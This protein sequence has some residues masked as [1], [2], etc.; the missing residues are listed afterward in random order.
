MLLPFPSHIWVSGTGV[1][2]LGWFSA[3]VPARVSCTDQRR[4]GLALA[5][6][7]R[8]GPD[9]IWRVS[10]AVCPSQLAP[11][12]AEGLGW[13]KGHCLADPLVCTSQVL[14]VSKVSPDL[15]TW[16]RL[17]TYH[18]ALHLWVLNS[19]YQALTLKPGKGALVSGEL[20]G[21]IGSR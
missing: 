19:D 10:P 4:R 21:V 16:A 13:A 9:R 15:P 5:Q 8:T 3:W 18:S 14:P 11:R 7:A 17:L 1:P 2:S 6:V 12:L 20:G